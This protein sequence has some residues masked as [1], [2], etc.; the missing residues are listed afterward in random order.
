MKIIL[1]YVLKNMWEKKGRTLLIVLAVAMSSAIFFSTQSLSGNLEKMYMNVV[2]KDFGSADIV[3]EGGNTAESS[4][5]S[6]HSLQEVEEEYEGTA[7][8]FVANGYMTI[9][10]EHLLTKL[11]GY[12]RVSELDQINRVLMEKGTGTEDNLEENQIIIGRVT[13]D[14]YGFD[15][16]EQL[17]IQINGKEE[18]FD[19]AGIAYSDGMFTETGAWIPAIVSA[20]RMN[21][22]YGTEDKVN[23]ILIALHEGQSVSEEIARLSDIMPKQNVSELLSESASKAYTDRITVSFYLMSIAVFFISIFLIYSSFKVIVLERMPIIGVFRSTGASK[24]Q[25]VSVLLLEAAACAVTGGLAGCAAGVGLLQVMVYYSSPEWMRTA[26]MVADAEFSWVFLAVSFVFSIVIALVSTV[27][28]VLSSNRY[29]IS[30]LI[31]S[32]KDDGK[33]VKF[34]WPLFLAKLGLLILVIAGV[35]MV[36]ENRMLYYGT[37]ACV[38][39]IILILLLVHDIVKVL[40]LAFHP[41]VRFAFRHEGEIALKNLNENSCTINNVRLLTISM[42]VFLLIN[43]FGSSLITSISDF[44]ADSK[45]QIEV[46]GDDLDSE[47]RDEIEGTEGVEQVT[48]LYLAYNVK[49]KG[50][51]TTIPVLNGIEEGDYTDFYELHYEGDRQ[52][53]LNKLKRG[54]HILISSTLKIAMDL[55]TGDK[56]TLALGDGDVEYKVAGFYDTLE[57]AALVSGSRLKEQMNCDNYSTLLIRTENT[58]ENQVPVMKDRISAVSAGKEVQVRTLEEIRESSLASNRQIVSIMDLFSLIVLVIAVTGMINNV[59]ISF[60]EKKWIFAVQRSIGMSRAQ[61][62]GTALLEA[63]FTGLMGSL[64][65]VCGGICLLYVAPMIMENLGLRLTMELAPGK[66][67]LCILCGVFITIFA[68]AGSVIKMSG[69]KIIESIKY[70]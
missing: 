26:G 31:K 7:E 34:I 55:E 62:A 54:N 3:V 61:L 58:G 21:R 70:E 45:Y 64:P 12:S 16:G 23:S 63:M 20:E 10:R 42:T 46:Q 14:R 59:I 15:I 51:N 50:Y 22:I 41:F 4:V 40:C 25:T 52:A 43:V 68:S 56:L 38:V 29:S 19:I 44:F 37:F 36:P 6:S 66:I 27:I 11:H 18:K 24:L 17:T 35:L 32:K 60:M 47:Y 53:V 57:S 2:R 49:I 13:A 28:P 39:V 69:M 65:G 9:G 67:L 30:A 5:F 8:C 1:K 33:T 48:S